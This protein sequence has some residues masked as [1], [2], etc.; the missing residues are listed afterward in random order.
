[1]SNFTEYVLYFESFD[2]KKKNFAKISRK[3]YKYDPDWDSKRRRNSDPDRFFHDLTS[4]I[5]IWIRNEM[6][7]RI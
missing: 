5:L 6:A 3:N 7:G 2:L 1:M 4:R